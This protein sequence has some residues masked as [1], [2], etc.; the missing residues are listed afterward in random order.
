MALGGASGDRTLSGRA[1]GPMPFSSIGASCTGYG[2]ATPSHVVWIDRAVPMLTLRG[3]SE[4][5]TVMVVRVPSGEMLCNDD[6]DGYPNPLVTTPGDA[7]RYD[8]WVGTY[9]AGNSGDYTV[10]ISSASGG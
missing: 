9:S 5:D 7:G 8:I 2:T 1:G 3:S 10:T 6:G 4:I